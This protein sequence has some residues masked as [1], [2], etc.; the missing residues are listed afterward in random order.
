M[1]NNLTTYHS[2]SAPGFELKHPRT[3]IHICEHPLYANIKYFITYLIEFIWVTK[4][5]ENCP[6]FRGCSAK[7]KPTS[8]R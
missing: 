8:I 6:A 3:Y 4:N 7:R 2:A 5:Q 1:I